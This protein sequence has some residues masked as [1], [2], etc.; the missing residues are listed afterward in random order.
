MAMAT[1][2]IVVDVQALC[3]DAATIDALARLELNA[4]R[5]GRRI[6][7]RNASRE[8]R[9]LI[10]FCGLDEVLRVEPEG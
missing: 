3:A 5:L 8:L 10:A 7:L 2:A 6:E 9:R 1:P 4:Q